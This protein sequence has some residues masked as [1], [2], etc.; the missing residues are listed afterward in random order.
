MDEKFSWY[1]CFGF[2]VLSLAGLALV[3]IWG[4]I[5]QQL[6]AALGPLAG[7]A[8]GGLVGLGAGFLLWGPRSGA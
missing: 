8:L 1:D 6:G 7:T 3:P 5:D 2:G 4:F